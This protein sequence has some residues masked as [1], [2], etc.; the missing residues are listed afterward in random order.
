ML[1]LGMWLI[2]RCQEQRI[3]KLP[4]LSSGEYPWLTVV[5][6]LWKFIYSHL[7]KICLPRCMETSQKQPQSCANW[8]LCFIFPFLHL[9]ALRTVL[10]LL[11]VRIINEFLAVAIWD[12]K[13]QPPSSLK[14][15]RGVY[16][17]NIAKDHGYQKK[18]TVPQVT[19]MRPGTGEGGWEAWKEISGMPIQ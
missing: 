18:P 16:K 1:V 12:K 15:S 9:G 17:K 8:G 13:N 4:H 11:W 7:K 5:A 6:P 2:S 10:G 19:R 14:M 3:L